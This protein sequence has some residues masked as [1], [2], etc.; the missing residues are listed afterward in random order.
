MG[1]G[2]HLLDALVRVVADGGIA[3]VSVRAVAA[4]A[5]VSVAQVQY[6]FRT[7][8]ELVTAAYKHVADGLLERVRALDLSGPPR[9]ALRRVLHVWLPVDEARS[10]DA[11]VWLTF[12]AAAPVSP[13][14]GPLSAEMDGDLKRWLAGFL[15]EAQRADALDPALD[16]DVEA[17]L[18]LAVQDGL[19]VQALVLPERERA[20]LVV[21]AMD[22][23][24]DRLFA[25]R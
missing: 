15:G 13:A 19:V 14:I 1:R 25:G 7:K 20:A 5:G 21:A 23:Y 3:A 2:D 22:T 6:Y 16:P 18:I 4:E 17:A 11:K 8:E 9:D 12:A 24:L 10:R